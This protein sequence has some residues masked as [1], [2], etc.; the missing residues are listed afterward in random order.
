MSTHHATLEWSLGESSC[1]DFLAG[2]YSRGHRIG[3][4]EGVQI[5]AS[6]SPSVVR[7]PFSVTAAADPEELLVAA[8]ASC[9]ML[10]FLDVA[11]RDGFAVS[12]YSD[13]PEGRMGKMADG[14]VGITR[15]TLRPRIEFL[16]AAPA[17]EALDALHHKA[18]SACN[19]A[20]S[21]KSEV[22]VEASS[23]ALTNP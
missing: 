20:N 23:Q 3:F 7:P 12:H 5:V 13:A 9:H 8:A 17:A 18:H 14:S 15:V 2:R 11:K 10:W 22:V 19:I 6:S 1:A 21:L 4:D 16:G